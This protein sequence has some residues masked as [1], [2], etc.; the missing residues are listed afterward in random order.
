M[1][2]TPDRTKQAQEVLFSRKSNKIIHPPLHFDKAT[3]KLTHTPETLWSSDRWQ[4]VINE[5]TNS[6]IIKA[7]KGIGLL[8]KL[9]P[10]TLDY[11]FGSNESIMWL[12]LQ[13]KFRET[14][15]NNKDNTYLRHLEFHIPLIRDIYISCFR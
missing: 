10:I 11:A 6:K 4:T 1:P 12:W 7:T 8:R 14:G 15:I 5:H 3:V 13:Y 2:L 9:Q